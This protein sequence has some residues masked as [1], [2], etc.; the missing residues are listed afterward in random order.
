[1][2]ALIPLATALGFWAVP[3][4]ADDHESATGAAHEALA[5][6]ARPPK[7]PPTLPD[8]ASDRAKY[9]QQNI[10]HGKHGAEERAAHA[11]DGDADSDAAHHADGD[12]DDSSN[13]SAQG[14]AASAAK[15]ANSDSHAAAGQARAT[16]NH[17]GN[18]PGSGN[19]G[20]GKGKGPH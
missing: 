19:N 12:S 16:E 6:Q 11:K 5:A 7:T 14:A 15:S 10:A 13:K 18:P 2:M 1:M 17:G 4:F 9:V 3:T 8:Q 20:H